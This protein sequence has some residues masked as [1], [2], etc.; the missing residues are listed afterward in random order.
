V[1]EWI[2]SINQQRKDLKHVPRFIKDI[3][4]NSVQPDAN[5]MIKHML[6]N[7]SGEIKGVGEMTHILSELWG[8]G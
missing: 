3:N 6:G 5:S 2:L 7:G 4:M 8:S 1:Y